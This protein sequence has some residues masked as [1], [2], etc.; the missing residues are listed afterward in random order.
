MVKKRT[1]LMKVDTLEMLKSLK[2]VEKQSYDDVV[3]QMFDV[4]MEE[5]GGDL[6]KARW[7]LWLGKQP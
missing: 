3:R 1:V 5:S 7:K 2:I 4:C 6:D